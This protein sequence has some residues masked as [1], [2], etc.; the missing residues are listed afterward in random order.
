MYLLIILSDTKPISL[1]GENGGNSN[2]QTMTQK[3]NGLPQTT[4]YIIIGVVCGVALLAILIFGFCCFR[5]R[6]AGKHER[7]I[8]DAKY[9]KMQGE[10]MAHRIGMNRMRSEQSLR[11]EHKFMGAS[12]EHFSPVSPMMGNAGAQYF[13]TQSTPMMAGRSPNP[14]AY[15]YGG[16]RGYQ[17]Y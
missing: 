16:G 9:E 11:S 5:Q 17:K 3:W 15:G 14:N 13:P 8:E 12:A 7:L 10:V 2:S 1:D 6:R 4:K